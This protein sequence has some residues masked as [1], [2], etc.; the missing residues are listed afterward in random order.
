[1]AK[2]I[3][4]LSS[5]TQVSDSD[6]FV[7]DDGSHNYKI[8]WTALKALLGTVKEIS[9]DDNG[10]I[11]ITLDDG[12]I[13]ECTPHDPA[14]QDK[15]TFDSS[16]TTGSNNPVTSNGIKAELDKKFNSDDYVLFTGATESTAGQKGIV[17]APGKSGLYLTSDGSWSEPD[18]TPTVGS[19]KLI[20]SGAVKEAIDNVEISVDS[21][22]SDYSINPVQNKVITAKMKSTSQADSAYHFGFY[23]DSNG[24]LS[25]DY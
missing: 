2:Y 24:D 22:L 1:M 21:A 11:T 3:S 7:I 4:E 19:E 17:P 15:L 14:K 18:T 16:P 8:S 9:S 13:H 6:V 20:T 10:K 5:T 12:T 23:L 25:Y